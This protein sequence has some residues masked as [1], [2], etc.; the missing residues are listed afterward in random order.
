MRW[1]PRFTIT[2]H[3][4][5]IIEEISVLR[6]RIAVATVQVS[7]IP[8][9]QKDASVR[10]THG[11]TAIE[12]NPL[13][14][15]EVGLLAEGK[16][17]PTATPRSKRE[18]LNYFAGLRFLERSVGKKTITKQDLLQL[19]GVFMK[20]VMGQGDAG[21]YRTM[22]VR[23]GEYVPP[24]PELVNRL[25]K[26]LLE[27]WNCESQQHSPVISSAMLHSRF[28]EIHPFADGNGRVGR[29]LGLWELYRRGFDTHHIFS[30]DEI[31]WEN[32]SRY[33]QA[34]ASVQRERGDMTGWIE[35]AAEVLHLTLERV[36]LRTKEFSSRATGERILLSPRQ[37]QLL[38]F[39][40][41]RGE[42]TP[43]EVWKAL[44]MTKQ[45]TL[46]VIRPLIASGLIRRI[47]TRKYGKYTLV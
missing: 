47:G 11:S 41:K 7:W 45:G 18:V 21:V 44:D 32:R 31:Y 27:W 43:A 35:F 1:Q 14:L 38:T 2:Q 29:A 15:K 30:V 23:V 6:E 39:L 19:H 13:T 28:E 34:L 10:N 16:E 17:L 3:L 9:L 37:E 46:N 22:L 33:Y 40:R 42:M 26:E 20:D 12:G 5:T 8:A 4:L 24:K 25:M 36:W